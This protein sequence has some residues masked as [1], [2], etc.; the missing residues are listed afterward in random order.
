MPPRPNVLLITADHWPGSLLGVEG[1]PAIQTPTLDQFA[2]DGVLFTQAYSPC[3]VCI[4]AR[5]SLMTGTDPRTH[6]DR[7][8]TETLPMPEAPTLAQTFRDAG[9]QAYAVG[10]LHVY[11]PRNRIGFD[12]VILEEDGRLQFGILDDYEIFLGD[13][14]FLGQHFTH[15]MSNNEYWYRPWHLAED[16][17]VTNWAA[18][19]M[20]RAIRRRDPTRPGFWYLSFG[21]PHPPLVP[22]QA[23]LDL[24][25]DIE[26]PLPTLGAWA[27]D[28]QNL[29]WLLKAGQGRWDH[30]TPVQVEG[31]IRAFYALCTH[32]DHQIR[33]VIGTLWEEGLMDDTIV[34]FTADHGDMLGQH[35][36][37]AK[38]LLYEGSARVPMILMGTAHD[39]RVGRPR[40]DTRLAG[41]QD[42]MPTLLDLAGIEIPGTVDGISL[43]GD[44][45]H[46]LLYG[47]MGE[48]ASATRMVH[49]GQYKLIYYASGNRAQLFDLRADPGET[50]DLWDSPQPAHAEV[51]QGLL[52]ALKGKL[53][54]ADREWLKEGE[55]V[56]LPDR[57]YSR[58][59]NRDLNHHRGT[60]W[61][62]SFPP[63]DLQEL[64]YK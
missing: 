8:Y 46:E 27:Q 45:Q 1:H 63:E 22:L 48:A 64:P 47:E 62:V 61:P 53:Y 10:K 49:D 58:K 56:G 21:H 60:H 36:L 20:S 5:R 14:G 24:Y 51:R 57:P 34:M 7:T 18:N 25:R 17:H 28:Q 32:I 39:T 50:D 52:E 15:G 29:P 59:Q 26:I 38:Q 11:P 43:V 19:Q 3:P 31:A 16:A 37:W 12:D 13:R 41:L 35:G 23:Y 9:Y 42:V 40:R 4:P 2:R 33:V 30:L 44:R 6:G 55:L 54:G